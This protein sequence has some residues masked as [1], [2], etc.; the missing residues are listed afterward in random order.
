[1][2]NDL[3]LA[4][5]RRVLDG[6]SSAFENIVQRWQGALVSLAFRFCRDRQAAEELAQDAFLHIY[7]QLHKFRGESAFSTWIFAV[8]LNLFRSSLR[9]RKLP[10][11]SLDDL[12][13]LAGGEHPQLQMEQNER[14][15]FI[16]RAVAALPE[17]YRDAVIIYYF[18]EMDLTETAAILGIPEGTAKAWL[19]RGRELLR[20]KFDSSITMP[21]LGKE[22]RL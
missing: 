3:D 13:E 11:D 17:H 5:V 2:D 16:R 12:A 19:H 9:R 6:D 1:V 21:A 10:M 22:V 20:K 14:E 15:E 4:N 18:R 7:R 8:S